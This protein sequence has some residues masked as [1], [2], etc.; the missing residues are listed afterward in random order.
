MVWIEIHIF[1]CGVELPQIHPGFTELSYI[2]QGGL[3]INIVLQVVATT[4]E[5]C[6]VHVQS[7][8]VS[9]LEFD[10]A[11]YGGMSPG[12]KAQPAICF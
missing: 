2:L 7:K 12:N 5:V 11:R 4:T 8:T 1:P 10:L 6:Y 3:V 9:N